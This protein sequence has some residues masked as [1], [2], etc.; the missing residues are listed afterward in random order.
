MSRKVLIAIFVALAM[1]GFAEGS[2]ASMKV[3]FSDLAN[4]F[5]FTTL[6]FSPSGA[7]Q[8]GLHER[9]DA[10][11]GKKIVLDELLDDLSPAEIAR[12]RAFYESFR[13]RLHTI[14]KE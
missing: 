6:G 3:Q 12:Q 5:V 9:T 1:I 14:S 2:R 11:T 4:E 10:K 8:F 7:S 13:R